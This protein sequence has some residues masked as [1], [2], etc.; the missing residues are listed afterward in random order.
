MTGATGAA[1]VVQARD[2]RTEQ[3]GAGGEPPV[4]RKGL[5]SHDAI[6]V[7][8]AIGLPAV[9]KILRRRL[10]LFGAVAGAVVLA[11]MVFLATTTKLYTAGVAIMIDSRQKQVLNVQSVLGALPVDASVIDSEVQILLSRTLATRVVE[12]MRL[13]NDPEFNP[14]L[15]SPGLVGGVRQLLPG[16]DPK[17]RLPNPARAAALDGREATVDNILKKIDAKRVGV[18]YVLDLVFTSKD[19][20]KSQRIANRYAELYLV[21]QLEAKFEATRRANTWLSGRL[22]ELRQ[23]VLDKES[24]VESFRAQ[25]G[26]L[27]SAGATITEQQIG[28]ISGQMIIARG[29]LAER[30]ARLAAARSQVASGIGADSAGDVLKSEVIRELRT[31]QAMVLRKKAEYQSMYGPLNPKMLQV[32]READDINRQIK[33]ETQRIIGSLQSEVNVSRQRLGAIQGSLGSTQSTLSRN[34]KELPRLRE[35]EREAQASRTLYESFLTRF[36]ETGEQSGIEQPDAQIVSRATLPAAPSFPQV[37]LIMIMAIAM[38]QILAAAAVFI[39]EAFDTRVS[40]VDEAERKIGLPVLASIPDIDSFTVKKAEAL[41]TSP[42]DYLVERPLSSFA[43]AFRNLRTSLL[44]F[45]VDRPVRVAALCSALPGEGK[46]TSSLCLA[47]MMALSGSR[48]VIIDC[49]LRRR[50]LSRMAADGTSVGLLEVLSGQAPLEAALCKDTL[51]DAMVLPVAASAFTPKDVFGSE[52]M[53]N[54]I[55]ELK[56]RFDVVL[57]DTAPILPIAEARVVAT[58]ADAVVVLTAW[59]RTSHS[60]TRAAVDALE[61]VGAQV[62]GI[63]MTRVDLRAKEQ[64][65]ESD[66]SHYYKSYRSYYVD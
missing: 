55:E 46:T 58:L 56:R 66:P 38:S 41:A 36:K 27:S 16:V 61:S 8:N 25:A 47:R 23:E 32:N 4:F 51:T 14:Y 37:P 2:E 42:Q 53:H 3:T 43:E 39:A 50:S 57:F 54:L 60:A 34:N 65:D 7:S 17:N 6:S 30:E 18:T 64:H 49:D 13:Y 52:A 45:D 9:V 5:V 12:D 40:G 1:R 15:R 22:S 21:E 35:L 29:D 63:A 31:Q 28:D 44:Y 59:R 48:V 62:A 19:P 20:K 10:R 33:E 26:L 24:A 11:A